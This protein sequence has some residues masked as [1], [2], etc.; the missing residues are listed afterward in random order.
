LDAE[1]KS[2]HFKVLGLVDGGDKDAL[3]KEQEYLDR[4]SDAVTVLQLRLQKPT[5]ITAKV[6]DPTSS[7]TYKTLTM[8]PFPGIEGKYKIVYFL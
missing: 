1:L 3:D 4:H 2:L 6:H 7:T 8:C 5:S